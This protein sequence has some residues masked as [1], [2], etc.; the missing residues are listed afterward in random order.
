MALKDFLPTLDEKKGLLA[1]MERAGSSDES[2]RSAYADLSECEKYMWAMKDVADAA[3][4]FDCM[5]YRVQF[6]PRLDEIVDAVRIVEKACEEVRSS[7]KLRHIMAMI[8]TLVNEINT[9]GDGNAAFGFSLD[10]LLKLNEVST[11]RCVLFLCRLSPGSQ[12]LHLSLTNHNQA[13]A[14]DRKTSVLHYL[15]KIVMSN[16]EGG[17]CDFGK[18]LVH[19]KQAETVVLD[20]LIS[21]MKA[22][23]E[24]LVGV[25]KT[26][27]KQAEEY[28]KE[29]KVEKVNL[30][31]LREQRTSIR[32]IES[33]PQYNKI[34]HL[35]GRTIME[36]FT[37]NA[38]RSIDDAKHL[39]SRVQA[40]YGRVL[41]YLCED[42][43]MASN[44]FFGT[45]RRFVVEFNRAAEQVIR[46][47]KAKVR[48]LLHFQFVFN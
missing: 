1:Y 6:F 48:F 20:S 5:L 7:E 42:E 21:D 8:L 22:L 4:K 39:L 36:R 24:E 27:K 34:D 18:D 43:N 29:G 26:A 10:A 15:V 28:E 44:D 25:R 23:E 32:N 14:F 13:K 2:K 3:E 31:E 46:E 35:T 38:E 11:G 9:G 40:N 33:I 47:D 41:E 45:M 12:H 37:V 30:R 19:I 17:L 16:D